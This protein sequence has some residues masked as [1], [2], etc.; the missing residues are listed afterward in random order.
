VS[1]VELN[2]VTKRIKEVISKEMERYKLHTSYT[3]TKVKVT[4]VEVMQ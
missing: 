2:K 3:T 4:N 1:K